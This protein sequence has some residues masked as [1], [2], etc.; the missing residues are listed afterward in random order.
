MNREARGCLGVG[1][2][3]GTAYAPWLCTCYW[4]RLGPYLSFTQVVGDE[5]D[6]DRPGACVGQGG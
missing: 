6:E 5:P 2:G 3:E 1:P 4:L